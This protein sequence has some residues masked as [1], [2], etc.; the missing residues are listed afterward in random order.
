M[1]AD[2]ARRSDIGVVVQDVIK[3]GYFAQPI[4][5]KERG[6]FEVLN[7]NLEAV[8]LADKLGFEEAL[9]GE[10]FTDLCEPITSALMFIARLLPVTERIKL[11]SMTT[12]LPVYHPMMLAGH[13]AM[14]DQLAQGR[15]I[16]GIGPGGQ[17]SDIEAFGNWDVD[18]NMKM[19]EIF[20]QIIEIWH[21]TPPYDQTGEF[22]SFSTARTLF[23]DIGQGIAPKPYSNPHPPVV[24]TVLAPHSHGITKA[25]ER[26]WSPISSN[27]VQAHWVATHLPKL[28][29]GQRNIGAQEDPSV[30]R[31]AKSIFVADDEATALAYA[32]SLDGPYGFYFDNIIR[33]LGG[34]GRKALFAAYPEQPEDQITVAQSLETQVIAGTVDHVVDQLLA[35]RDQVGPFGTLVYTAHDWLDPALGRR[36]MEL[37][38]E[39]VL[40]RLNAA[41]K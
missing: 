27:Y 30:W 22:F 24:V 6:Y 34:A 19:L 10:H 15:F 9:F 8:I 23:P 3:L 41:I 2:A 20:D 17:P 39:Q 14:I 25:A 28:I 13:V 7:E 33:K 29:E 16:W 38:A 26:G 18:R 37:M 31:V 21:G 5:P 4:H 12:N 36:S 40:P 32:K 35:F 11:G 1:R